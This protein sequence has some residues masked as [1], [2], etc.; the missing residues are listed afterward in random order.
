MARGPFH[1]ASLG[2]S[3]VQR[4]R[5]R[6]KFYQLLPYTD[7]VDLNQKLSS[8]ENFYNY[9][10]PHGAFGGKTPYEVLRSLLVPA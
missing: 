8:W 2:Q 5:G 3:S 7:D 9:D 10:R 4:N 6:Y 1:P